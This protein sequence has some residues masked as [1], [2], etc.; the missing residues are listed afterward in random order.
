M[1][2]IK[3]LWGARI[4]T[5]ISNIGRFGPALEALKHSTRRDDNMS[6][7]RGIMK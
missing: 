1:V 5:K 3:G 4:Y 7:G 2:V 6:G